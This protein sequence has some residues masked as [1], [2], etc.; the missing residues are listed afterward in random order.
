MSQSELAKKLLPANEDIAA[1][2]RRLLEEN[3]VVMVNLIGDA[4]SGKTTILRKILPLLK[5]RLNVAVIEGGTSEDTERVETEGVETVRI[6][7]RGVCHLDAAMI[8][9]ALRQLPLENIDIVFVENNGH[10]A[11]AAESH[12][13]NDMKIVVVSVTD[14][15]DKP[16][17]CP[18][19]FQNASAVLVTRIDLLPHGDFSLG[20]YIEQLV[21]INDVL[22][23]FPL[24]ALKEEGIAEF[25]S[26]LGRMVWKKRR[27]LSFF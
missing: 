7:S 14:G 11:C 22:K 26:F 3:G 1:E 6:G 12:L 13:G 19:A 2:N 4:G 5:T 15:M 24:A 21:A 9:E 10:L 27:N 20:A 25:S 16:A 23:I 17:T 8:R 18:A